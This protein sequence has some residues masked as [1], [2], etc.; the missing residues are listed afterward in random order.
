MPD[1]V[2][3]GLGRGVSVLVALV[4]LLLVPST[5][6]AAA[7]LTTAVVGQVQQGVAQTVDETVAG[8]TGQVAQTL[9][10][11]ADPVRQT[12]AAPPVRE[13]TQQLPAPVANG[14]SGVD[15]TVQRAASAEPVAAASRVAVD[16]QPSETAPPP[17][18]AGGR[19]SDA[20]AHRRGGQERAVVT[21]RAHTSQLRGA[22]RRDRS[23]LAVELSAAAAVRQLTPIAAA[24]TS[25]RAG[26]AFERGG[27]TG[28]VPPRD[29]APRAPAPTPTGS[30]S[31][32]AAGSFFSTGLAVLAIAFGLGRSGLRRR[33]SPAADRW[34]PVPFVS[35]LE[36][37]G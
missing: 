15:T 26:A 12:V 21:L 36:R 17:P 3:R 25:P 16:P 24:P 10:R 2:D 28:P 14:S 13:L 29:E 7:D 9:D 22:S 27:Q 6:S 31:G 34:R 11:A 30:A 19:L 4:A 33:R 23:A 32:A 5:A 37:P 8:A 1:W 35:A 20:A 18:A